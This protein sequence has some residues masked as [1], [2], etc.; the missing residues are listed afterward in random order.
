M[1][2]PYPN[3]DRRQNILSGIKIRRPFVQ[4]E[5]LRAHKVWT[6][7][8]DKVMILYIDKNEDI[9]TMTDGMVLNSVRD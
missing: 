1:Q 8:E 5:H 9:V 3:R 6:I 7:A 4:V 2:K